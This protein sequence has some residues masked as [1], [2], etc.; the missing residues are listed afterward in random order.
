MSI[1]LVQDNNKDSINTSLIAIKRSIERI[2]ALL[3]LADSGSSP[4][5]SGLATKQELEDAIT[6]V[7]T[8]LAPVDEV[9][10]DNMQSVTSNA[11]AEAI[12]D[13]IVEN[14][15]NLRTPS[16]RVSV[17]TGSTVLA[18]YWDKKNHVCSFRIKFKALTSVS[19]N[20]GLLGGLP[21][22]AK[23]L[24]NTGLH[25][26]PITLSEVTESSTIPTFVG[27]IP[28]YSSNNTESVINNG[29]YVIGAN[30]YYIV[31]GIYMT[32]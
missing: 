11:V 22:L 8:D 31:S 10:L 3:G 14:S 13:D 7:E 16:N 30:R 2:N 5:L 4:D 29:N 26:F 17:I 32:E 21:P 1:P 19:G 20:L 27:V 24:P 23:I 6:Q 15:A 9:T 25:G 28:L 18:V 12:A